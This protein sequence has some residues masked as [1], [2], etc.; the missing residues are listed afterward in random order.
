[1]KRVLLFLLSVVFLISLAA[2]KND[3]FDAYIKAVNKTNEIKRGQQ[4]KDLKINMDFDMEGLSDEEI[5]KLSYFKS[6]NSKFN[7]TFDNDL[8]KSIGRNYFNFG[9][10]GFDMTFYRNGEESFIKM[11]ILGKYLLLDESLIDTYLKD[12][13]IDKEEKKCISEKTIKELGEKWIDTIKRD[14]VFA[15][16]DSVMSTP[17]GEVKVTEYTIKLTDEQFKKLLTESGDILLKD[18][19]LKETID[20]YVRRI[21]EGESDFN[22]NDAISNFKEGIEESEFENLSYIAFI[23]IDGY[24]V[25]EII[26][27]SI[28]F[29]GQKY[30]G[31]NGFEYYLETNSWDIEKDQKFEFP[32]LT[33]E[34]TMDIDEI[35]KGIPFIF[36]NLS[37]NEK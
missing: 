18:E 12:E 5:K 13:E 20:E 19:K 16:K 8:N 32:E 2:C 6:L 15:G 33:K 30:E 29:R 11:P 21:R 1:M 7:I 17:E 36:E 25:K 14:D 27:F 23:D 35:D 31:M 10:L 4:S 28:R 34:N 37:D 26:E 24:I 3:D 22:F 9:G